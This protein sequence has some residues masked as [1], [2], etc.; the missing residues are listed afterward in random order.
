MME[1]RLRRLALALL[2]ASAEAEPEVQQQLREALS[3]LGA[4]D[5]EELLQCCGEYLR[6]NDKLPASQRALILASMAAVVRSHLEELGQAT[7]NDAIALGAIE[8]SRAKEAQQAWQAAAGALLVELGRRFLARVMQELLRR[9]PP[10]AL[11]PPGLLRT[12]ADLASAN[13]FGMVPFL[14]SILGTLLPLL[15]TARADSMKC[16]LCY[17]LQRFSES[18]QEY[19]AGQ[20]QGPDPTVRGDAFAPELGAAFDTLSLQW[21]QSRDGKVR[22]AVLEALGPMSSLIP[23]EKLQEQLPKLLPS[24]LG[25]YKKHPEPFPI[26][27]SL[28]QVLEAAVALGSRSLEAQLEPLLGA[29]LSQICAPA[30]PKIPTSSKNHTELLR[31]FSV[32]A[33]PFPERLLQW[34]L[35]RLECSSERHRV[36]ALLLLRHLLNSAPSQMEMQKVSILSS[37]KVPLQDGSPK[38][39]RALLQLLSSLAHHGFLQLPGAE[40][41]LEFL[42]LQ[43]SLTPDTAPGIPE[44]I[45]ED[46]SD[47]DVRSVSVSTLV[48][49]SSTVPGLSQ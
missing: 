46:P 45:P 30:D 9:F 18:I 33:R 16:T 19:L 27:K 49:L 43:C 48:L 28:C 36:G 20:E 23:P 25:L 40:A 21:A 14:S 42:V 11:P 32:L 38:V 15:G 10:G 41:L 1:S 8:I 24:I 31:C 22:Q 4:A 5:P 26:S 29:L 44:E 47:A 2:E 35:P 3:G 7:A 12:C 17:A 34:L 13:V 37:L 6:N 39:R